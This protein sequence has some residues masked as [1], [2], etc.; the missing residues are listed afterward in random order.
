MFTFALKVKS[1]NSEDLCS[2]K[3]FNMRYQLLYILLLL[4]KK[5][6]TLDVAGFNFG[7]NKSRQY[8]TKNNGYAKTT[9][10]VI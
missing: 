5:Y 8:L 10:K 1:H 2:W 9:F 4:A 7:D 3:M 6:N